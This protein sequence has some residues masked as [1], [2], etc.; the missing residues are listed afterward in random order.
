MSAIKEPGANLSEGKPA[1]RTM[2]MP[3]TVT[4]E[5]G[6]TRSSGDA[7][8]IWL[9]TLAESFKENLEKLATGDRAVIDTLNEDIMHAHA[10]EKAL[11]SENGIDSDLKPKIAK[12]LNE[13]GYNYREVCNAVGVKFKEVDIS[14][15]DKVSTH[16]K[17]IFDHDSHSV[18]V[19]SNISLLGE[20]YKDDYGRKVR[21]DILSS[22]EKIG[23]TG[24]DVPRFF[25]R[26]EEIFLK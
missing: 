26:L 5:Q 3:V 13:M 25:D 17:R 24:A 19:F 16:I 2:E 9:D 4:A 14:D 22:L 8:K 6:V 7:F 1:E 11:S 10:F 23:I 18:E 12:I 21:E 15:M 20:G